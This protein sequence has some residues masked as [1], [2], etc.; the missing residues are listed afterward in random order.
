MQTL[1]PRLK[2]CR[3]ANFLEV[4]IFKI[5]LSTF[6]GFVVVFLF[7]IMGTVTLL[8]CCLCVPTSLEILYCLVDVAD[9]SLFQVRINLLPSLNLVRRRKYLK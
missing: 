2:Q 5:V 8:S 4:S 1:I 3:N 6:F 9:F 7:V